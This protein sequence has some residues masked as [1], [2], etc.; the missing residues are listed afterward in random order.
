MFKIMLKIKLSSKRQATFPKKVCEALGIQPGDE[1][2]LDAREEAEG[3]VW[4]VKPAEPKNRPW[5][6]SLRSYAQGKSHGMD[7]IRDSIENGRLSTRK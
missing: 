1:I 3:R 7:S 2:L 6:G 4:V 5:L